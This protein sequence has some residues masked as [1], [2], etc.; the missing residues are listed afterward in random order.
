VLQEH[1]CGF[2]IVKGHPRYTFYCLMAVLQVLSVLEA[3][4]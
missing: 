3:N 4:W 1:H 2:R